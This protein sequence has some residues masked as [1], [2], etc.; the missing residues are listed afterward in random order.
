LAESVRAQSRPAAE[1]A[2]AALEKT[3]QDVATVLAAA[4]GALAI[5]NAKLK[6]RVHGALAAEPAGLVVAVGGLLEN[7]DR[8]DRERL[9]QLI[10]TGDVAGE[11]SIVLTALACRRAGGDLWSA[12]RAQRQDLLSRQPLPGSVVVL[13]NRLSGRMPEVVASRQ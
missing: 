12:F 9:Q 3:P 5:D 10:T 8:I 11:D 1:Q 2:A 7:S 6:S 4:Y 13:V